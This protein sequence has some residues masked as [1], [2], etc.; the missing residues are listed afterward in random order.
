MSVCA[1]L[2]VNMW[3]RRHIRICLWERM[4]EGAVYGRVC[5]HVSMA[6]IA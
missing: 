3:V 5:M 1:C 4:G 2:R 6:G